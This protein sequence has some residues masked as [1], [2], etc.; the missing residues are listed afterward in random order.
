MHRQTGIV[1]KSFQRESSLTCIDTTQQR[2]TNYWFKYFEE[3]MSPELNNLVKLRSARLLPLVPYVLFFR[4][5]AG[6]SHSTDI[7]CC[8]DLLLKY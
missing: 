6:L 7:L 4:F 5:S 3:R 2:M 8:N 1:M